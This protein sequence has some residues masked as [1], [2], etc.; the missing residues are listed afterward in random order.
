MMTT[1]PAKKRTTQEDGG[2]PTSEPA[3]K[4]QQKE[5]KLKRWLKFTGPRHPRVG[6]EFQV[7]SLPAPGTTVEDKENGTK[8]EDEE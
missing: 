3:Q 2:P 1:E 6:N 4:K 5:E 8:E 7:T